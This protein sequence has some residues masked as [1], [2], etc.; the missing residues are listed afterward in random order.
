MARHV[1]I[2]ARLITSSNVAVF[3]N[4]RMHFYLPESFLPDGG[5]YV[6]TEF[7]SL[8]ASIPFDGAFD[9]EGRFLFTNDTWDALE[10]EIEGEGEEEDDEE[11]EEEGDEGE[12]EGEG[13]GEEGGEPANEENEQDA[14]VEGEEG[15]ETVAPVPAPATA[16]DVEAAEVAEAAAVSD[17]VTDAVTAA[18]VGAGAAQA[19]N[20]TDGNAA[21]VAAGEGGLAN[22]VRLTAKEALKS[23]F[24]LLLR[25]GR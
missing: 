22:G 14:E 15:K 13:E 4:N 5:G 25:G 24:L 2:L 1:A 12:D 19:A 23:I 11:E 7:H 8:S 20:E 3:F 21:V 16:E 10:N 18:I 9:A 6:G 17:A